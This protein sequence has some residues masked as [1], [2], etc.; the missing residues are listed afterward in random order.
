MQDVASQRSQVTGSY[1]APQLPVYH[2]NCPYVLTEQTKLQVCC[3]SGMLQDF[4]LAN[5]VLT[6]VAGARL[7]TGC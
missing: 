6:L 1:A 5:A 4:C 3:C 7:V 2:N